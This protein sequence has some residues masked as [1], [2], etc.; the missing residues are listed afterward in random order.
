MSF[1]SRL[2]DALSFLR[3]R[4]D[5]AADTYVNAYTGMGM[6]GKD[7][8]LAT[9]VQETTVL[10]PGLLRTIYRSD[11]IGQRLC[12]LPAREM[13]REGWEFEGDSDGLLNEEM[14]RLNA[15]A[16][17]C[18]AMTW[19]ALYGGAIILIG[20]N[21][22]QTWD[23]PLRWQTLREITFLR[24]VDRWQLWSA[25]PTD[26]HVTYTSPDW[27]FPHHYRII[28]VPF[29]VGMENSASIPQNF[30]IR[31]HESRVIRF[32]G[33]KL[34]QLSFVQNNFWHD[35]ILQSA[36]Q[37]LK[38][39]NTGF[40]ASEQLLNKFALT[41]LTIPD[42]KQLLTSREGYVQLEDRLRQVEL[43]QSTWGT[44]AV[45][46]GEEFKTF[47]ASVAGMPD[48]IDRNWHLLSAIRGIPIP[49][50][51]GEQPAGLNATG[52][53]SIR[54][55]YD[56]L[57]GEQETTLT[58]PL[59]YLARL[60]TLCLDGPF[61]GRGPKVSVRF[62][63]LWQPTE[64]E[65]AETRLKDA[66]RVALYIQEGV[67]TPEEAAN[68]LL[69]GDHYSG[70]ITLDKQARLMAN[71]GEIAAGLLNGL[72]PEPEPPLPPPNTTP[73]APVPSPPTPAQ[74]AP[75]REPS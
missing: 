1:R 14:D 47:F 17:L 62:N 69:G 4:R 35:S 5:N 9:T 50:L 45:G 43:L 40:R 74:E 6:V 72:A 26:F 75:E 41:V 8:S 12:R 48:L 67:V 24:P 34:P 39:V 53:A 11:G 30:G 32:D 46:S 20:A 70:E 31:V 42:L 63:P 55:W 57:R 49:I 73:N 18:D 36:F 59:N 27:A 2:V 56:T 23:K 60:L 68:S 29:P 54:M 13:T 51:T 71:V 19:G 52:D 61:R 64:G 28:P 66:Q 21:D 44:L 25:Y 7:P 3:G 65:T 10:G 58:D 22:G 15:D 37:A 33:V 16:Q 38:T